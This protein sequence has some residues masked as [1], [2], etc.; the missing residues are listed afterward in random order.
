VKQQSFLIHDTI[1]RKI[2]LDETTPNETRLHAAIETAGLT[3]LVDSFP[4]KLEKVIAENGKNISGGQRQRIAIARALYKETD[5]IIL[6][7]PFNELDEAS[8]NRLLQ[9][10]KQ[11]TQTGKM[12][13]LIT[14]NKSSLSFCNKIVSLDETQS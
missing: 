12:V 11:L 6:D 3:Q 1:L 9:H 10:F 2:V 7:E 4:E 13:I 5:L 8:E 14:H